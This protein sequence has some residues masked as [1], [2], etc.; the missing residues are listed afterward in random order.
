M[1]DGNVR[2]RKSQAII[3]IAS[4][5]VVKRFGAAEERLLEVVDYTEII[6]GGILRVISLGLLPLFIT[7]FLISLFNNGAI[8]LTCDDVTVEYLFK[9]LQKLK[10]VLILAFYQ[11]LDLNI[12][13]YTYLCKRLLQDLEIVNKLILKFSF[14]IHLVESDF[15]WIKNIYEIAIGDS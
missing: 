7:D 12:F 6:F 10:V 14:N 9:P 13:H 1:A 3:L 5:C 11:F 4:L 8:I 2:R 15:P